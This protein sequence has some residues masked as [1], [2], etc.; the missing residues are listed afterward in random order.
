MK[1]RNRRLL[2]AS[3]LAVACVTAAASI[4]ATAGSAPARAADDGLVLASPVVPGLVED[5]RYATADNFL[6]RRVY[7]DD[8]CWLRREAAEALG[9]VARRLAREKLRLVAWDCYRPLRVQ[10]EMWRLVPDAR[11]VADPRDGS[12]HNRGMAVDV[13]LADARGR[14]LAMP[15]RFDDFTAAAAADAPAPEPAASHRRKLRQAMEAEGFRAL[16][17]EW[18]HFDAAGWEAYPVLDVAPSNGK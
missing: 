13:T 15:T 1:A 7:A 3:A 9:R 18:W 8:R 4:I 14:A 5:L 16:P 6:H 12:K 17:T 11:Y 2:H 10:R